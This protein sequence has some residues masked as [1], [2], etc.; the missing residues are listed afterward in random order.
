MAC[1]V[2]DI[3][4]AMERW[5]PASLTDAGDNVGLLAGMSGRPV[6]TLLISLDLDENVVAYAKRIGANMVV[7]HHPFIYRPVSAVSDAVLAGRLVFMAIEAG[8][9][10]FAS[11]TNLDRVSGGVNDALCETVGLPGATPAV[12][13]S[14]GRMACLPSPIPL[15]A[16]AR[17]V[18]KSLGAPTVRVTGAKDKPVGRIYI[19]SGAG[20][21]DIASAVKLG[22]DCMLTG[23]IGYHDGQEAMGCGLCVVEVGHYY[24]EY[25]VLNRIEKHLQSE[26]HRLKYS[27]RTE[28]YTVPTC[29]FYYVC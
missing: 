4:E 25:P 21:H 27:V 24:S 12:E 28:I 26:F 15:D 22:A 9:A 16:F 8:V 7:A 1:T 3:A 19:V 11:H 14:I 10:V 6:E 13:G 17:S 23:E 20:R 29:P 2:G 5:A 18:K